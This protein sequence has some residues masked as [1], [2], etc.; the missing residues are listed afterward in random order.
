MVLER[1]RPPHV[2]L[3]GPNESTVRQDVGHGL[4]W[5]GP[6]YFGPFLTPH[7]VTSSR[8]FVEGK[9]RAIFTSIFDVI[10]AR[11]LEENSVAMGN[12]F[13][14]GRNFRTVFNT[15]QRLRFK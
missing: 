4:A 6:C 7:A 5:C 11:I 12:A 14:R 1:F 2:D 15:F 13:G 10:T 9:M 3:F 8:W